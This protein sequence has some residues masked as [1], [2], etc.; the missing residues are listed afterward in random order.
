MNSCNALA[1]ALFLVF[2]FT[3]STAAAVDFG[4]CSDSLERLR[5]AA[6]DASGKAND[7]KTEAE[8]YENCAGYH[9]ARF[10]PAASGFSSSE[11]QYGS[12]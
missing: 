6:R 1:R 5:R 12:A 7:A 4:D 9:E 2:A 8:E 11:V 3:L 10:A